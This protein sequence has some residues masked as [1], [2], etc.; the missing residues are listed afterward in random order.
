MEDLVG[1][2]N[3]GV[4]LPAMM[5]INIMGNPGGTNSQS[6]NRH[7]EL[8]CGRE[9]RHGTLPRIPAWTKKSRFR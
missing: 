3:A 5:I 6:H 4:L 2:I 7:L 8:A 1:L 9:V